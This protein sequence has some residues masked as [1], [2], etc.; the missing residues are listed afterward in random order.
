M[1]VNSENIC[2][3]IF[4]KK[5]LILIKIAI[6]I[7]PLLTHKKHYKLSGDRKNPCFNV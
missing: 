1:R 5:K 2:D 3:R 4:Y 7:S 6:A